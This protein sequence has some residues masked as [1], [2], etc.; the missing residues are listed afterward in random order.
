MRF[1]FFLLSLCLSYTFIGACSFCSEHGKCLLKYS[2][3]KIKM[4]LSVIFKVP[5]LPRCPQLWLG[6]NWDGRLNV[7]YTLI[8]ILY[9]VLAQTQLAGCWV[10]AVSW[11][12]ACL[13]LKYFPLSIPCGCVRHN[14]HTTVVIIQ[15]LISR[16]KTS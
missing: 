10:D 15:T 9:F 13:F 6:W 2:D 14:N 5:V 16:N 12:A 4:T 7:C 8:Q 11:A 1:H 3:S